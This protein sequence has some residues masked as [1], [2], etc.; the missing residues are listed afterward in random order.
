MRNLGI[1]GTVLALGLAGV[2]CDRV[3]RNHGPFAA[4]E[5]PESYSCTPV[6]LGMS[7]TN[8][9]SLATF[10]NIEQIQALLCGVPGGT[11]ELRLRFPD[12]TET[13]L[14]LLQ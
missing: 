6:E 10:S 13:T 9:N 8:E 14:Y 4:Q 7:T 2:S 5:T 12:K 11:Y 1:V 3:E